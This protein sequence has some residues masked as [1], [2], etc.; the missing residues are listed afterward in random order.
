MQRATLG[1][2][3]SKTASQL[4]G[5]TARVFS[6]NT[7]VKTMMTVVIQYIL[8]VTQSFGS[9]DYYKKSRMTRHTWARLAGVLFYENEQA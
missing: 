1:K 2:S 7:L 5:Q 8:T 9:Q 3:S 4:Q 6:S